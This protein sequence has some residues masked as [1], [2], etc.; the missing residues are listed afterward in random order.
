[1]ITRNILRALWMGALS[2]LVGSTGSLASD[3]RGSSDL[4]QLVEQSN[5]V[6]V[7]EVASVKYINVKIEG[8]GELPHTI[9]TYRVQDSLRGISVDGLLSLRFIGGTDGRGSFM[10]AGGVPQFQEGERDILFVAGNGEDERCPLVDCEWGR[11]RLH[12]NLVFNTQGQPVVD[13]TN[14]VAFARGERAEPFRIFKYPTP[15]F[16]DLMENP[17]VR[18]MLTQRNISVEE[19]RGQYEAMAPKLV[20]MTLSDLPATPSQDRGADGSVSSENP[21]GAIDAKPVSIDTFVARIKQL[22]G[23][24]SRRP[25]PVWSINPDAPTILGKRPSPSAPAMPIQAREPRQ[26]SPEDEEEVR[27]MK[28]QGFNPVLKKK[29]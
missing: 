5:L 23:Q 3:M 25:D 17:E 12:Q 8:G 20:V 14:D 2:C 26:I 15:R 7:G 1:M 29:Q 21:A 13:I 18:A 19:A 24:A 11:Y 28:E 9:V 16:D 4:K 6:I 10:T 27:R 22:H